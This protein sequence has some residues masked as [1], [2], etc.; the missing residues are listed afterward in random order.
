[1]TREKFHLL[2]TEP[3]PLPLTD[4]V[5]HPVVLSLLRSHI[6]KALQRE[7]GTAELITH[8]RF[9]DIQDVYQAR[10]LRKAYKIIPD[11]RHLA[12]SLFSSFAKR[13]RRV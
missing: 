7:E 9:P 1:M 10:R 6:L 5:Y 4:W 2:E 12:H 13:F 11:L 3:K 8:Y